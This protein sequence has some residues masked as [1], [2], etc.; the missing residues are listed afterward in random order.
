MSSIRSAIERLPVRLLAGWL[1]A[2]MV[3]WLCVTL[4]GV[5]VDELVASNPL[6]A[7][8]ALALVADVQGAVALM[9]LSIFG[10]MIEMVRRMPVPV[11][12]GG[13]DKL[14]LSLPPLGADAAPGVPSAHRA[15]RFR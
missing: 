4:V 8:Q 5:A 13:R 2:C 15:S 14:G 9:G 11:T 12:G 6:T 3:G 1:I 7:G 10:A